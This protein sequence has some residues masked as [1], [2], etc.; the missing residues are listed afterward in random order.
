MSILRNNAFKL[1]AENSENANIEVDGTIEIAGESDTALA[2]LSQLYFIAGLVIRN[3]S[4]ASKEQSISLMN[5]LANDI[6]SSAYNNL[7]RLGF[8][9]HTWLIDDLSRSGNAG[10]AAATKLSNNISYVK[11]L[12]KYMKNDSRIRIEDIMTLNSVSLFLQ[13]ARDSD[14]G[15][16]NRALNAIK[17]T[18]RFFSSEINKLINLNDSIAGSEELKINSILRALNELVKKVK[19]RSKEYKLTVQ[20][21]NKLSE[22]DKAIYNKTISK[23]KNLYI[24]NLTD[25]VVQNDDKPILVSEAFKSL[26]KMG[27]VLHWI[28]DIAKSIP[29]RVSVKA[30]KITYYTDT[31]DELNGGIAPGSTAIKLT[32]NFDKKSKTG[33]YIQFKAPNAATIT[34]LYT[35]EHKDVAQVS[36]FK[37]ADAVIA[38][39]DKYVKRW[40]KDMANRDSDPTIRMLASVCYMVYSTGMRIGSRVKTAASVTGKM[41][42]GAMSLRL[43]HVRFNANSISLDYTGKK[44]VQQKHMIKLITPAD[45]LFAKNLKEFAKGKKNADILFSFESHTGREKT[46]NSMALGNYLK[47][48]GFPAGIHKVR[49]A[50]GTQ[51]MIDTLN[52]IKWKPSAKAISTT[53]KQKEAEDFFKKRVLEPIAALLG[54]KSGGDKLLWRTSIQNYCNPIPAAN[55]FKDNQLRVPKWVPSKEDTE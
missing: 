20:E 55:W 22:N 29:I 1:V 32:P 36:K 13:N 37:K 17:K 51:F 43:S 48:C 7:T 28:P 34:R 24:Q 21:R 5:K 4:T 47:A 46:L 8:T 12:I 27:H 35:I 50:R 31:M 10:F 2:K 53:S 40:I 52:K 41:T 49:H 18:S 45:K 19:P 54:H 26:D 44:N 38:G 3:N 39:M 42:Y 25:L 33:A 30:G 14:D 15:R 9:R 6:K 16:F 11:Q 23:L